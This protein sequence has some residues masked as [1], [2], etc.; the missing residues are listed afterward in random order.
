MLVLSVTRLLGGRDGLAV[1]DLTEGVVEG[2]DFLI[3]Q[4]LLTHVMM[5]VLR[6]IRKNVLL[7]LGM[8]RLLRHA[9]VLV[10]SIGENRFEVAFLTPR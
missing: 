2:A 4:L 10:L 8:L 6:V 9:V 7:R 3:R 5:W 1:S